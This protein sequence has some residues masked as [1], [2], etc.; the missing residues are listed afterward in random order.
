MLKDLLISERRL[1]GSNARETVELMQN[2]SA[3]GIPWQMESHRTLFLHS[4]RRSA[5]QHGRH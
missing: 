4:Y 1:T 5:V 2:L 3:L